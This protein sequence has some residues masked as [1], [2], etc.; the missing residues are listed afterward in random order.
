M[1]VGPKC[2]DSKNRAA[3]VR[4]WICESSVKHGAFCNSHKLIIASGGQPKAIPHL[5]IG[6]SKFYF[7]LFLLSE[8][9]TTTIFFLY[10]NLYV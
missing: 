6:R 5:D 4:A 8:I 2:F 3:I 7:F 10:Q 9:F 1:Y